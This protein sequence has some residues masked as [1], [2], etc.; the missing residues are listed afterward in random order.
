MKRNLLLLLFVFLIVTPFV[1]SQTSNTTST[2][3]DSDGQTWNN[4][5]YTITFVPRSGDVQQWNSGPLNIGPYTG[6]CSSSGVLTVALPDTSYITPINSRWQFT[7]IPTASVGGFTVTIPVVGATVDLSA[8]LSAAA[9]GP[10]FPPTSSA[11]G[12][13]DVE[14][15]LPVTLGS[16]YFNVVTQTKR[17]WNGTAWFN[18]SSGSSSTVTE[19]QVTNLVN[20]LAAKLPLAGG[21]MTGPLV[22]SGAPTSGNHP[23]TK[24]YADAADTANAAS[25]ATAQTT[26]NTANS[27]ASG[28]QTTAN[29]AVTNA[30]TAQTTANSAPYEV[31]V[32]KSNSSVLFDSTNCN[33][34]TL[35][36]YTATGNSQVS[37]TLPAA[38]IAGCKYTV[39]ARGSGNG[40]TIPATTILVTPTS[41][42]TIATGSLAFSSYIVQPGQVAHFDGDG[43]N[44]VCTDCSVPL[45]QVA[46]NPTPAAYVSSLA[47]VNSLAYVAGQNTL[48]QIAPNSTGTMQ[49]LADFSSGL[50]VYTTLSRD[51]NV[52]TTGAVYVTGFEKSGASTA[53]GTAAALNAAV[54]TAAGQICASLG[55]GTSCTP[56]LLAGT[57]I[58]VAT[59]SLT[60]AVKADNSTITNASGTLSCTTATSSQIGC[61]KPD[62][63]TITAS[64]G[65]LACTTGT[66]SQLG[67]L[68]PDGTTITVASGVISSTSSVVATNSA[69][70]VVRLSGSDASSTAPV[71]L[72][73]PSGATLTNGHTLV[74]NVN[75]SPVDSGAKPTQATW[76]GSNA[77]NF[78]STAVNSTSNTYVIPSNGW[79]LKSIQM[80]ISTS[81]S[82]AACGVAPVISLY[83]VTSSTDL[84]TITLTNGAFSFNQT[85]ILAQP[86]AG[87][88]IAIKL[89]TIAAVG[90][91]SGC[92]GSSGGATVQSFYATYTAGS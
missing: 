9:I 18:E 57:D 87:D 78:L 86:T 46:Y 84:A 20:D 11:Y 88:T 39:G 72:S 38:T 31:P 24:T 3:T 23:V 54:Y 80:N 43:G 25:A 62:N 63:A 28:A 73:I 45:A 56:R 15:A 30:A 47:T 22:L 53:F 26:A 7:V 33:K 64:A 67:C 61:S 81:Y 52:D 35:F 77:W 1:F 6:T 90:G 4:C 65:A 42:A 17:R 27:A 2:I 48:A 55:A 83:D 14:V 50:P 13:A 92:S 91:G 10:R 79:S 85:T 68:K 36:T 89:K 19:S 76:Y 8:I 49:F 34:L 74:I 12:Y 60:G 51:V 29:T 58:P 71:V 37:L 40:S 32:Y 70:G 82:S 44:F 16:S 75:G 5:V 59:S 41:P 21:T 69:N 66:T